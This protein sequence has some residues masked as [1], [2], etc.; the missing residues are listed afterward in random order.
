MATLQYSAS[1]LTFNGVDDYID[2]RIKLYDTSKDWIILLDF[3]SDLS[4]GEQPIILDAIDDT[5][6]SGFGVVSDAKM[7]TGYYN[8]Y[9]PSLVNPVLGYRHKL[10][11]RRISSDNKIQAVV[12][13]N[14]ILDITN[15]ILDG[16]SN[17]ST[18]LGAFL[19]GENPD[20]IWKGII[21]NIKIW[22]GTITDDEFKALIA[23]ILTIG[24]P[25]KT[26]ISRVEGYDQSVVTFTSDID[27]QAWE[28][29]ATLP[30]VTPARGVGLLVESG[31]TLSAN[32][33]ATIYVD[34]EEL[35]NGDNE[36][37]ITVY[38][39]STGGEWSA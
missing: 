24:T 13:K 16:I 4:Q 10:A 14:N 6:F 38:G 9:S 22:F 12:D 30:G 8:T 11:I 37:T 28:A 15:I 2:T 34:D 25:S 33:E 19:S 17:K 35:T 3:T 1:N 39:Q 29:R 5:N 36:Y 27:L 18:Y 26:K 31:T 21:N 20:Y 23:P 7:F 32:T